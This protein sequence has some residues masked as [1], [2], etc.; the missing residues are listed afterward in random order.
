MVFVELSLLTADDCVKDKHG[1]ATDEQRGQC[2]FHGGKC[3]PGRTNRA[4]YERAHYA[5]TDVI[6]SFVPCTE[7]PPFAVSLDVAWS[8]NQ[9]ENG[10]P[11]VAY[12]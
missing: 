1:D 11:T 12:T 7:I 9:V 10:K 3:R 8:D 2:H 5:V 6:L 4:N